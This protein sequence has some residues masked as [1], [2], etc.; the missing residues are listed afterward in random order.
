MGGLQV[1]NKW[2]ASLF[3]TGEGAGQ[4]AAAGDP[5]DGRALVKEV[6]G[7]E[8]LLALLLD[9]AH[10]QV[11]ALLVGDEL[12]GQH[13]D[14]DV[15]VLLLGVDVGVE[16]GLAGLDGLL[17]GVERVSALS[18]IAL[19]GGGECTHWMAWGS[20]GDW[21]TTDSAVPLITDSVGTSNRCNLIP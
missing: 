8:Q 10:A 21:M 20:I 13:L 1:G 2:A 15:G 12:R 19:K 3:L 7:V 18:H 16:V 14:D 17:N 4:L 11:L 6:G 5:A 9:Q